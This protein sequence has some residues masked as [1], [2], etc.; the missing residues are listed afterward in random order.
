MIA[1][2][3]LLID[4]VCWSVFLIVVTLHRQKTKKE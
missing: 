1:A 4:L 3:Y 2:P